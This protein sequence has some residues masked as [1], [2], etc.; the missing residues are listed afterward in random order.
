MT[1]PSHL[2]SRT[3]TPLAYGF[4]K[5]SYAPALQTKN[6]EVDAPIKL[7]RDGIDNPI[8]SELL[9]KVERLSSWGS[10][11]REYRCEAPNAKTIN[12]TANWIQN[13][14]SS[15]VSSGAPWRDLLITA[16]D[17]GEAVLECWKDA[18]KLTVRIFEGDIKVIKKEGVKREEVDAYSLES[19][20]E[21]WK[22]LAS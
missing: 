9:G 3:D 21:L 15:A 22:W 8:L 4:V 12:A 10:N 11:W 1:S 20:R 19:K 14:Y 5:P 13:L 18:K 16:S 17:E 7:V 6:P 2:A